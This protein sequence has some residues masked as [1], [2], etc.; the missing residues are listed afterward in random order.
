MTGFDMKNSLAGCLLPLSGSS[1][2]RQREA[3]VDGLAILRPFAKFSKDLRVRLH[4]FRILSCNAGTS[5]KLVRGS[6]VTQKP[7]CTTASATTWYD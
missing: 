4:G 3:Q 7:I 2:N 5:T 1:A 6:Q